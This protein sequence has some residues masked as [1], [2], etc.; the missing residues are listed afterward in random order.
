MFLFRVRGC[1]INWLVVRRGTA[2]FG[3]TETTIPIGV[4][5]ILCLSRGSIS[6][7]TA[8]DDAARQCR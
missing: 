1:T 5:G 8:R 2:A 4:V 3:A 7:A 6:G